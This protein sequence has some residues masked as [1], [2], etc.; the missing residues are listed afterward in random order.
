MPKKKKFIKRTR[1]T[2][3]RYGKNALHTF[4]FSDLLGDALEKATKKEQEEQEQRNRIKDFR[5]N[6]EKY[7]AEDARALYAQKHEVVDPRTI[8]KAYITT[9]KEY[10]DFYYLVFVNT[11]TQAEYVTAKYLSEN[12]YAGFEN[13]TSDVSKCHKVHCRRV[14][15]LDKYY[16]VGRVPIPEL[17]KNGIVF[18][19]MSCNTHKFDYSS[20]EAHACYIFEGEGNPIDYAEGFVLCYDCAKKYGYI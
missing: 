3:G 4:T 13:A 20:Y 5:E 8:K 10:P 17:M 6:K 7:A 2:K 1:K 11:R 12:F 19:C 15:E 14:F 18:K 9:T 16:D